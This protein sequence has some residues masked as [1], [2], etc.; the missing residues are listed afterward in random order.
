MSVATGD[1]LPAVNQGFARL[2]YNEYRS[3]SIQLELTRNAENCGQWPL[4]WRN[5]APFR[6]LE[7]GPGRRASFNA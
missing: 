3:L 7:F 6:L 5:I 1:R 4:R 2:Y